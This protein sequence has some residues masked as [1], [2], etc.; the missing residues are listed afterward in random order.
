M[1]GPAQRVS[2]EA[3]DPAEQELAGGGEGGAREGAGQLLDEGAQRV[4][5][6]PHGGT[7]FLEDQ[8]ILKDREFPLLLHPSQPD[9]QVLF[10]SHK[11]ANVQV[12]IAGPPLQPAT[13]KPRLSSER[14][15]TCHRLPV[16]GSPI[17]P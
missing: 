3:H 6:A 1:G 11:L 8:R 2:A 7:S 14:L 4:Y 13:M 10:S 12:F 17:V 5:H 16:V 9:A 15:L